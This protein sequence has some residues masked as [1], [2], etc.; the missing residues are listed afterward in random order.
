MVARAQKAREPLACGRGGRGFDDGDATRARRGGTG[1]W[2]LPCARTVRADSGEA[3][4]VR[5]GDHPA[6]GRGVPRQAGGLAQPRGEGAHLAR[7]GVHAPQLAVVRVGHDQAPLRIGG[8]ADAVLQ[9]RD[10]ARAIAVAEVEEAAPHHGAH[11]PRVEVQLAHAAR[12]AVG[13]VE[14]ASHPREPARLREGRLVE[15]PVD[16]RLGAGSCEAGDPTAGWVEGSDLVRPGHR[17]EQTPLVEAEVPRGTQRRREGVTLGTERLASER[18]RACHDVHAAGGEVDAHD[19]VGTG[20]GDEELVAPLPR[21]PLRVVERG[22]VETA[23]AQPRKAGPDRA[24]HT[25]LRVEDQHA[26]VAAVGD[27]EGPFWTDRDFAGIRERSVDAGRRARR[28]PSLGCERPLGARPLELVLEEGREFVEVRLAGGNGRDRS[29]RAHDDQCRPRAHGVRRPGSHVAVDEDRVLNAIARDGLTDVRRVLLGVELR[30]MH[31]Q[32]DDRLAREALFD[33]P[34]D[35]DDVHAVDAAVRP[36]VEDDELTA[37]L[38]QRERPVRVQPREVGVELGRA[39]D[40][41]QGADR[42]QASGFGLQGLH[43]GGASEHT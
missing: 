18:P 13:D 23:D 3:V 31:A 41:V 24:Q 36:E 11:A 5:V 29:V 15:R 14:L 20:V 39:Y 33:A 40:E 6:A 10:V 32:H 7:D 35:R 34:Q 25:T 28:G 27:G 8:D 38:A 9:E 1:D 21:Q 12:L 22:L 2:D 4:R 30:R 26:V 42:L 37:E 17:D 19:H 16:D 43:C